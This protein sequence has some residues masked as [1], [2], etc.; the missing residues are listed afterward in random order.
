[1][2]TLRAAIVGLGWWGRTLVEAVQGSSERIRFA[3]AVEPAAD[4][5]A[6]FAARHD[7]KLVADL[8][9]VLADPR[10]EAVVLATP[11]SQHVAQIVA[12][13]R[14]GKPVFSEKPLALTLAEARSAVAA[15]ESAGVVLGL[16]HDRRL[17]PAISELQ[18][19]VAEGALGEVVHVEAQYSNDAMSRGLSGA[20]RGEAS[21]APGG[22]MP[23]PGL[24]ALDT[25]L[26]L[27]PKLERVCAKLNAV[28]P[29]PDPV[30]AAA[31]LLE[32]RGGAT[33]LLGTVRGVPEYSRVHVFGTRGWAELRGF[34]LLTVHLRDAQPVQRKFDP[35][36]N[37][38]R[39]LER[40][41]SAVAGE[42]AFPV[43]TRAMLET[44]AAFEASVASMKHGR[45]V[46]VPALG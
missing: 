43:T 40:F 8:D 27:G 28:R 2:Q 6:E 30:D 13:A 32:F 38:G 46:A 26:S 7:L 37:V 4:T 19:L 29:F 22:G 9:A 33:G 5:S 45:P 15:C 31:L 20:W 35:A 18:R 23:G 10:I 17:L 25:L 14:A 42:E 12:A 41:A 44:V 34:E 39:M 16:G 36:L 11:H 3:S 21:E 1:M 24:H